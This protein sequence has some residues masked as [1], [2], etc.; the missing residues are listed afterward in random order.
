MSTYL[1]LAQ[2]VRQECRL[3]G[4]GP[5]AVTGQV[6]ELADIVHWTSQAYVEIQNRHSGK[7][8]FL[9]RTFTLPVS[10]GDDTYEYGDATDDDLGGPIARFSAWRFNDRLDPPKIYLTS[11]GVGG[12]R[13]LIWTPW[14]AFKRVYKIAN[15]STGAPVHITI[16]PQDRIVVGPTPNDSYTITGD[17]Y[18]SAQVLAA[19]SDEPEMPSQFHDLIVYRAM[20][21][22]AF[23]E[24]AQEILERAEMEGKPL[25]RQL[26]N[27]Q[28]PGMKLA[29]PFA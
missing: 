17:F 19:D 28:G 10:S 26:D 13:W 6:G 21:K 15:Q 23:A 11:G 12:Q 20:R 22:Y 5:A 14:E 7:W 18:R 16:D 2:R 1:E 27:N 8:R 29:G 3:A 25:M 4:T 24:S 9:R